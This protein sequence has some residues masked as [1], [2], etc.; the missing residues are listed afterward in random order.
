MEPKSNIRIQGLK[1][2]WK[3]IVYISVMSGLLFQVYH[4]CEEYFAYPTITYITVHDF[5]NLTVAPLTGVCI[6]FEKNTKIF[7]MTFKELFNEN[8]TTYLEDS[9]IEDFSQRVYIINVR[10]SSLARLDRFIKGHQYCLTIFPIQEIHHTRNNLL[11]SPDSEFY[12]AHIKTDFFKRMLKRSNQT[13]AYINLAMASRKTGFEIPLRS[14][15]FMNVRDIRRS[16]TLYWSSSYSLTIIKQQPPP[17]D[18]KC[19]GYKEDNGREESTQFE[20][21]NECI[22]R[23]SATAFKK[24][25]KFVLIDRERFKNSSLSIMEVKH[26]SLDEQSK[27]GRNLPMFTEIKRIREKCSQLCARP[28]CEIELVTPVPIDKTFSTDKKKNKEEQRSSNQT[29]ILEILEIMVKP[30]GQ[31][32]MIVASLPKLALLDFIVY[33]LSCISFWTGFCP[34]TLS[35]FLNGKSFAVLVRKHIIVPEVRTSHRKKCKHGRS[36]KGS[37]KDKWDNTLQLARN[38]RIMNSYQYNYR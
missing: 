9:S 35:N 30:S 24:I 4:I 7:R 25:P 6:G 8:S 37:K 17:Y 1:P 3:T 5:L 21:S 23:E 11:L 26:W 2:V 32:L 16:E 18:T 36:K 10:K 22:R 14:L 34:L 33:V 19:Q 38:E 31:P 13:T 29:S 28:D 15:P 12:L 20:C 27:D